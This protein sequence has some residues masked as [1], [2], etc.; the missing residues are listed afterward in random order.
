MEDT[1]KREQTNEVS[2]S[3]GLNEIMNQRLTEQANER[4]DKPKQTK[5]NP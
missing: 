4:L 2:L 1:G 5:L 3:E